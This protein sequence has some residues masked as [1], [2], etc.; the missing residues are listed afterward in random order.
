MPKGPNAADC[1]FEGVWVNWKKGSVFG[2]TLTLDRHD[3]SL[4]SP[5]LALLISIAGSQLWRLFQF[6]LHQCR[7]TSARKNFLFHQQQVTLRNANTDINT[8]WQVVKLAFAWRHQDT[9]RSFRHSA[10]LGLFALFHVAL[11]ILAGLF[12]T[13]LLNAG[14]EVLS[15]SPWCG[16]YDQAYLDTVYN[17]SDLSDERIRKVMELGNNIN[18]IFA[19]VQQHVDIISDSF[20]EFSSLP[21][22]HLPFHASV[23]AG[24]CP[25]RG[26]I[27]HPKFDGALSV[28]TG[29]LFSNLH[30]G[31]NTHHDDQISF[32]TIAQCAPL[33]DSRF[34]SGWQDVA[35]TTDEA[36]YQIADA[37][38]GPSVDST[39]NATYSVV[40]QRLDCDQRGVSPPYILNTM[41]AI[42]G[43][44]VESGTADFDPIPELQ[45]IDADTYL[46]MMSFNGAYVEPVSDPWFSAQTAYND[47]NAFCSSWN[48]VLYAR[49]LPI[50]TIG[51]TQQ[52][53]VCNTL[54]GKGPS[55]T[56]LLSLD[57]VRNLVNPVGESYG[58]F[59]AMQRAIAERVFGAA[60][61]AVFNHVIDKLSQSTSA[62]LKARYNISDTVGVGLSPTQWQTEVEYWFSLMMAYLQEGSLQIGSG[63]FAAS[64][65]YITVEQPSQTD[66]VRDAAYR[67]C[68]NQIIRSIDHINFNYFA[69]I[70]TIVLCA[71]III[72]GLSIEDIV[73]FI[74]QRRQHFTEHNGKQDMWILNSD[75]EM[76]KVISELK[77]GTV[78]TK[79]PSG[80]PLAGP[81][82]DARISDLGS[83]TWRT[84]QGKGV[85]H[86]RTLTGL[87]RYKVR[88]MR[89]DPDSYGMISTDTFKS[90]VNHARGGNSAH[91][92]S[93]PAS[94][95]S[96]DHFA[97]ND[98]TTIPL[99]DTSIENK[100]DVDTDGTDSKGF[101]SDHDDDT[102]L[103]QRSTPGEYQTLMDHD[104]QGHEMKDLRKKEMH[105]PA[106]RFTPKFGFDAGDDFQYNDTA[107]LSIPRTIPP[108][109]WGVMPAYVPSLGLPQETWRD[110]RGHVDR[111]DDLR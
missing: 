62:P 105:L 5:A 78:W 7:A 19:T 32:R 17:A 40:K 96:L 16:W 87:E 90:S 63:Q 75:I 57:Q 30:L 79:S 47:T 50:T 48:R 86:A 66:P 100:R 74:R 39:R 107:A 84:E 106:L 33:D 10:P 35:A 23:S 43:G 51:C 82:M 110:L 54:N 65:D 76:L 34:V 28:D 59:N 109:G 37:R 101:V 85:V 31:F 73:S 64:T 91:E 111:R 9:V 97:T 80:V 70:L 36:A 49:D 81:G 67:L 22:D 69:L 12:A 18:S 99:R 25:F 108:T 93:I 88:S 38:Y 58:T 52:W 41:H 61:G 56:P 44:S 98:Y 45:V 20:K 55:C 8:L 102:Q 26:S 4:L 92:T 1:I 72:L 103:H 71:V 24:V 94:Q 11:I 68:Q 2:L 27:C 60:N 6:A 83:N 21:I 3:A 95:Q 15:R 77:L 42:P 53:Q 29:P 89:S 14:D 13:T 46:V 104:R